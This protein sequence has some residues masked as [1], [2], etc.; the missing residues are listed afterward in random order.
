MLSVK[1]KRQIMLPSIGVMSRKGLFRK[2][3]PHRDLLQQCENSGSVI[4]DQKTSSSPKNQEC[5]LLPVG[6][7]GAIT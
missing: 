4:G 5:K 1:K 3:S 2:V 6:T 7:P